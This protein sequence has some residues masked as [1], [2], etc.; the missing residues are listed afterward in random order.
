M[1]TAKQTA[2]ACVS[3]MKRKRIKDGILN[4]LAAIERNSIAYQAAVLADTLHSLNASSFE[5]PV[6]LNEEDMNVLYAERLAKAGTEAYSIYLRLRRAGPDKRCSYCRSQIANTLDHFIPRTVIPALSIEPWNLVPSCGI[7]NNALQDR[8]T[9]EPDE[10]P[11]H[12]YHMPDVGRWLYGK[13]VG[14][15]PAVIEFSAS[16]DRYLVSDELDNRIRTQFREL[17]LARLFG[18]VAASELTVAQ[19]TIR[20]TF[21][22]VSLVRD[23]LEETA[24]RE[25]AVDNNALRGVIYETMAGSDRFI[26]SNLP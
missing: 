7:C 17:R 5:F 24:E 25:F 19:T 4:A 16:P 9:S 23:H 13:F 15:D 8:W 2:E 1:H 14:F 3:R 18:S 11:L 26:E 10:R 6:S 21:R 12:P 20:T 22:Q